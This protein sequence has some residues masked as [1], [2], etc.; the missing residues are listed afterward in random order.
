MQ[1][2]TIEPNKRT[3]TMTTRLTSTWSAPKP[4]SLSKEEGLNKEWTK[5]ESEEDLFHKL[6]S[7]EKLNITPKTLA[8]SWTQQKAPIN[9]DQLPKTPRQDPME[10][11]DMS[12]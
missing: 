3:D 9:S 8:S 1:S 11:D 12:K 4:E 10:I 2:V 6:E 5:T 7:E